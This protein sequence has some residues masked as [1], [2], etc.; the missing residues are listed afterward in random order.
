MKNLV[1]KIWLVGFLLT[2]TAAFALNAQGEDKKDEAQIAFV[3]SAASLAGGSA[4]A[5]KEMNK[6]SFGLQWSRTEETLLQFLSDPKRSGPSVIQKFQSGQLRFVDKVLYRAIAIDGFTGIQKIWDNTVSK[7]AGVTNVDKAK[8]DK[9]VHVCID[10]ILLEYVN[11]GGAGT[12][13]VLAGYDS[14][15]TSWPA[16][17]VASEITILQDDNVILLDHPANTCGSPAD[18]Q[19]GKG[20]ADGYKLKNPFILEGDK[21][22]EVRMNFPA[23]AGAPTNTDFLKISLF[24]VGTRK[25]GLI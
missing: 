17:L 19:M 12:T 23:D 25:R 16:G 3:L 2:T 22:F 8:L 6:A 4:A 1:I 18:S 5:A 24:G 11:S 9:D 15:V 14:V 13:T 10:T 21:T 7:Q 20:F